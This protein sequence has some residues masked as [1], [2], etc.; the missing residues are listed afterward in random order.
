VQVDHWKVLP[1]KELY[2]G[3]YDGPHATPKPSDSGPVFLGI[4]NVTE[5][6][7]LDFSEIRHISEDDY[8]SWTRRIEPRPGDI[9]FTYEA[10]LNRYAVVPEAFRGCLGRRMALI[11]PNPV[12]VDTHFLYYYFFSPEWRRV[13][14][15][16]L[17]IGST[18]D[19]IPLT[20][21]PDF[22]VNLPPLRFQRRIAEILCAYD[23]LIENNL[24]RIRILE[25]MA[26]HLYRDWFVNY[27][28]PGH[29]KV[30][31]FDSAV[32]SIP[33]GWE[34]KKLKEIATVN[35]A[36]LNARTAP[37]RIHYID[38][39]SV[40]PGQINSITTYVFSEAP[41]RARRVIQHGDVIW[42]CVRPNRRSH[43]LVVKPEPDTI[44]STGFAVLTPTEVPFPF[45][46]FATTT[47][48][49]VAFLTNNATGAA[50]PA[51][52]AVTFENADL[53]V[54]PAPLLQRFGDFA[55]P[56]AEQI[57]TLQCKNEGLRT[58]RDLLLP[59]LLSGIIDLGDAVSPS[60]S[61]E[62]G[63]IVPTI[64]TR[65]PSTGVLISAE[66]FRGSTKG[67]P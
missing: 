12:K 7:R 34:V 31:F 6:G 59:R 38:I 11:R 17:L 19:R 62:K 42:S 29:E 14:A 49:F 32:G 44:A 2:L 30:P 41:G 35:R 18:V 24:Q 43:A 58:T 55:I 26:G 9:V 63:K 53:L 4:K 3:L 52:T 67:L 45:L 56:V 46:Y 23:D 10:T 22:P 51:V 54:P 48:E 21:F 61:G 36:Q 15:N 16:N 60:E 27:R 57:F 28:F 47:D 33:A 8:P 25:K 50:Y 1:I 20:R 66:R 65:T 64:L 5:D 13:I 40:S 39:S 37:E